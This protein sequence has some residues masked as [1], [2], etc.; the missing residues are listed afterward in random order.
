EVSLTGRLSHLRDV[1]IDPKP[2]RGC[3]PLWI[4]GRSSTARRRAARLGDAWMPYLYSPERLHEQL[5]QLRAEVRDYGRDPGSVRV[6]IHAF[7]TI[8]NDYRLARR[9]AVESVSR[10]YDDD[11]GR[12]ADRYLVFG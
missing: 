7:V 1:R 11:A 9:R 12:F 8:E 4:A 10:T 3:P 2:L 5:P 6:A